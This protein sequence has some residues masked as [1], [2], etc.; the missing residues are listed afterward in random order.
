ME[1]AATHS[2][3]LTA[4]RRYSMPRARNK[5][6]PLEELASR[7][8]EARSGGARVVHCHGCFDIFHFGHVRH[9]EAARALGDLLVVTVTPD[10]FV[11]K[12][13]GRPVFSEQQRAEVVASSHAVAWVAVNRWPSA[14]ETIR[15]VKPTIYAKGSEYEA[16]QAASHPGFMAEATACAAVGTE[17]GFTHED[18]SSSTA[19]VARLRAVTGTPT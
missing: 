15:L 19:A 17:V 8:A 18:T 10:Q 11:G 6:L 3:P 9:L 16:G 12:G 4:D 13:P 2:V 7:V 5:V 1:H 14:V